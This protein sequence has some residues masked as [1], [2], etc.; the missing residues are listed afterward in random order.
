MQ[1][2]GAIEVNNEGDR[3][4]GIF[5]RVLGDLTNPR[6]TNITTGE[7]M[8]IEKQTTKLEVDNRERPFTVFD[9]GANAKSF[10][11]GQFV[12]LAPGINN[13]VVSSENYTDHSQAEV[14]I[15]YRNTYE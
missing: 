13:I 14:T 4:A 9:D 11:L 6:I 15:Y 8:K 10:K 12:Y 5:V 1:G 7:T 3:K 2:V